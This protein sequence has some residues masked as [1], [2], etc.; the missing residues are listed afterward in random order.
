MAKWLTSQWPS[1]SIPGL[2]WP[3][4]TSWA[5]S[6]WLSWP[7]WSWSPS[8]PGVPW[9]SWLC[10]PWNSLASPATSWHPLG[11]RRW[12]KVGGI[13][14]NWP[15]GQSCV[16]KSNCHSLGWCNGGS[17][18]MDPISLALWSPWISWLSWP[19]WSSGHSSWPSWSW[20][21][22]SWPSWSSWPCCLG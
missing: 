12:P 20:W 21:F 4:W 14:H 19:S 7:S 5:W 1:S 10:W 3:S 15:S 2:N 9:S 22:S 13:P 8:G 17:Y 18:S 11:Q 16:G 6:S